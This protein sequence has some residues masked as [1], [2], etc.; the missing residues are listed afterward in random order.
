MTKIELITKKDLEELRLQLLE[1]LERLLK[2]KEKEQKDWVKSDEVRRILKISPG[3]L[4]NLR[5]RGLLNPKKIGG[6]YYYQK[7]EIENLF[8]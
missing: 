2:P 4:Q 1:D 3:S 5:I 8:K 6:S 7:K